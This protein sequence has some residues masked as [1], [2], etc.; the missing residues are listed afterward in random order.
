MPKQ[1]SWHS[2]SK[3]V[4]KDGLQQFETVLQPGDSRLRLLLK[5]EFEFPP[6]G[7]MLRGLAVGPWL[8]YVD[9]RP[10]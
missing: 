10:F 6:P 3:E 2:L 4:P 9:V 8:P 7:K 1:I 5:H